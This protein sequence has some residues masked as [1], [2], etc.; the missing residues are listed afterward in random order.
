MYAGE[1]FARLD[2]G[3]VGPLKGYVAV[4]LRAVTVRS[5]W[6]WRITAQGRV[7]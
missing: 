1:P 3:V 7:P 5:V 2:S 4:T 6:K